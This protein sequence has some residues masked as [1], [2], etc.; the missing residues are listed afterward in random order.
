MEATIPAARSQGLWQWSAF[1]AM[2]SAAGLPI[3]LHAPKFYVDTYGVSLA[4]LGAVLAGLRL[5]DVV[6]DPA[7]GWLAG[8]TRRYTGVLVVAAAAMMAL[9]MLGL[10]AVAPPIAPIWWFALT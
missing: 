5:I 3:Y 10:F 6:Q 4:T 2:L 8:V 7:L 1:G 9:S